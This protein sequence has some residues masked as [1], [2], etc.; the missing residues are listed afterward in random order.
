VSGHYRSVAVIGAGA[1]GTA[2]AQVC[3][4]AGLDTTLWAREAEVAEAINGTRTNPLFLPGIT[5]DEGIVAVTDLAATAAAD[6][7]LAVTPAQH[8]RAMLSQ[9]APSLRPRQ[10][11]VLCAKGVEQGSL[12]L[13][14]DVL[15]ETAPTALPAV[16]SGPSFAG[17]VARGLPTAVTLAC[18][19]AALGE[20]LARAIATPAFRPYWAA[21]IV[22]AEAGGAVKNVLAIACGIVEGAGLGRSAHAAVVTRGFAELTRLAVALGAEAQTLAGLC[23]LGD[24]VLTCSSSQSRNMSLGLALGRGESLETALAGKLSIAEGLASAP[25]VR[26]LAEKL[27]VETPIC[28][29]VAAVLAGERDLGEAIGGLLSRPL[30]TER[31]E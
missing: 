24:L 29:A 7:I 8:T 6:I 20:A 12:K 1:W 26:A 11:V 15:A 22:G 5:L 16:L 28:E 13:M 4:R 21:D 10:P 18:P 2:L 14:S 27:D 30:R 3:R 17:E 25:A 9:L 31:E 19:D 23:G